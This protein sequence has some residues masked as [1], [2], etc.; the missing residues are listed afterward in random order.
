[1]TQ[2]DETLAEHEDRMFKKFIID[3]YVLLLTKMLITGDNTLIQKV[4]EAAEL[5]MTKSPNIA[6]DMQLREAID[7]MLTDIDHIQPVALLFTIARFAQNIMGIIAFRKTEVVDGT[8][9]ADD[10][11]KMSAPT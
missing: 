11:F 5:A 9:T 4:A 8:Y 1:M 3:C 7:D 10:F 6:S 2:T